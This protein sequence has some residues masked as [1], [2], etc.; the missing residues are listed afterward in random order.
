MQKQ[1]KKQSP[2]LKNLDFVFSLKEAYTLVYG[3][4]FCVFGTRQ[5]GR[6]YNLPKI[7]YSFFLGLCYSI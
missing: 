1:I 3:F 2:K 5:V 4:L 6:P 7:T